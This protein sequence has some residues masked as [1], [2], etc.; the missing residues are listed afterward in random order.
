MTRRFALAATLIAL[1][2][3]GLAAAPVAYVLDRGNSQVGFEVMFGQDP[4]TGTMPISDA[5]V[6]IDFERAANSSVSAV[7]DTAHSQASFPFATQ[8]MRGP[9]VLAADQ[10]PTMTFQ[11]RA[12]HFDG[13][14]ARVEGDLTIRGVTRAVELRAE[15]Y[16]QQGTEEGDRSRMSVLLTGAV[17][18][19][20]FGATGW[21]DMVGDQI[22]LK[23]LVRLNQAG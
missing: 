7:L 18:R 8:A 12:M 5:R 9:K 15:L 4:I 20:D 2:P 6:T 3:A 16:R 11:S 23:I 19:S 13:T 21:N 1:L 22:R 10:F 14:V 17:N